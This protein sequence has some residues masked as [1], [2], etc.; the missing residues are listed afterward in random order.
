MLKTSTAQAPSEAKPYDVRRMFREVAGHRPAS[1]AIRSGDFR[2]TY[3]ELDLASDR[4]CSALRGLGVRPG[5]TVAILS[6]KAVDVICGVL[7]VL[8]AG[9][10][11]VPL[12]P[13]TPPR[14]LAAMLDIAAP[15]AFVAGDG[16]GADLAVARDGG[17][18]MLCLTD[19]VLVG[20][21]GAVSA[22]DSPELE[23]LGPDDPCYLYFTSGST[24]QPK[25]IAGRFKSIAHFVSWEIETLG[26]SADWRV[27]QL[28]N[29]SF[30]A[31]LRDIFVP[32]CSGGT[33]CIP[34]DRETIADARRLLSWL[35]EEGIHLVHC[36]PSLFRTLLHVEPRP[37]PSLR[38][39]LMSGEP[40]LPIDIKR[41]TELYQ[42]STRLVNLYGPSET[43]MTK[44]AYFVE[45]S[46]GERRTIPIG[47]PMPG[48]RAL[49]ID[50]HGKVCPPRAVGEIYI[51]TP[52]RSLGYY[53][54]QDLTA[55]VFVRNPFTEDQEDLLYKTGDLGRV[56]S[57]GNFEFLGR[58]DSQVKIRGVR[59]ELDEIE[60]LLLSHPR[61]RETA[62]V[63]LD[64]ADKTKFLCAYVVLDDQAGPAG[65][66]DFLAEHLPEHSLPS[67]FVVLEELPRTLS[68]KVDRRALPLPEWVRKESGAAIDLPRSP[69]E[70]IMATLFAQVLCLGRVGIHE[71]F[72]EL[73][74]HSLLATQLLSRVRSAFD[75][76]IPLRDLFSRPTVAG[77]AAEIERLRR[78]AD[79][80]QVPTIASFRQDRSSPPPLSFAQERYWAGRHSE[81]RTVAKTVP[82]LMH[83]AGPFDRLC[84]GQALAAIVDRHEILRTSFREG[85]EG[86]IQVVH[87]AVPLAT[88]EVDLG[89]LGAAERMAEVRRFSILD[90]RLHF[91]YE[92]PPL[93]RSTLF[94]CA[95]EE[96]L[97][98]FTIHHVASD[99]WSSAVLI[100]E[101]SALYLAF[102]TGQPSPLPPLAVQFQDFARWQRRLSAQEALVSQVTFWREQ[103]RD[104]VPIDLSAGRRPFKRTFAAGGVDVEVP[105]ELERQLEAFSAEQGATLFM[106]LLA[107]FK[108]LLRYE[109]G[110]EDLVVP[111]SFANRN[112]IETEPLVGN[113]ATGLP[114]RTRLA[115]VQTFRELLHRVRDVTLLAHDH[116]EIFYERVVEGMSFLEEGDRGGPNTFRIMFLLVKQPPAEEIDSDLRIANLPIDTGK[117]RLDLSL[118][119]I[120][121]NRLAGRFRYNRDVLD[122]ARVLGMRDRF[123][124]ILAAIVANPECLLAELP[125][126]DPVTQEVGTLTRLLPATAP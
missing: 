42:S 120:Q 113:F 54:R 8:K 48:A 62:V 50:P 66:R 23:E 73:G 102:S 97:L 15:T 46:D 92:R 47:K 28:I 34:P 100:R 61:I 1:V 4:V 119:L 76:E 11:F 18:S 104:A 124:R 36:V 14:R 55:E 103:L 72:F 99:W 90:G 122:Q 93:F 12:D 85:P 27:S 71:S 21:N 24:G 81:A 83:L 86:P 115:G 91:D 31:F 80:Q 7:G 106:T 116:P 52:Y 40:L 123:F 53:G 84:L 17:L 67:A 87:P 121:G 38:Y 2:M 3:G 94:R 19:G 29:P 39:I 32:F 43:T 117:I 68:G 9:A 35:A 22:G 101:V 33:V 45:P 105:E 79:G 107:A 69:A 51:R 126:G 98:L 77:L 57:D 37:L 13:R 5:A 10:L 49:V 56:L 63:D 82:T 88:P 6:E 109:S 112:Q 118:R 110:Q 125:L 75:V 20:A 114:L 44:F 25:A 96:H 111:C 95:T 64:D 41:W 59:I 89:R 60:S 108:V 16:L 70:E 65:L 74:G 58:K 78:G 30:D 26:V